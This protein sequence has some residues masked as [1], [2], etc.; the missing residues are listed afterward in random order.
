MRNISY[1]FCL[2][3]NAGRVAKQSGEL[4]KRAKILRNF[5][6]DYPAGDVTMRDKTGFKGVIVAVVTPFSDDDRPDLENLQRL[7]QTFYKQGVDGILL[8]G[9]TG[10][11]PSL[12]FEEQVQI[13]EVGLEVS[14]DLVVM[15]G[16]GCASLADT[17]RLTRRAFELGVDAAVTVPPFYF[18]KVNTAGLCEYYSRVLEEGVP[19]GRHLFLYDIPQ[20]TGIPITAELV[21]R[22]LERHEERLGGIKDSTGN[23]DHA[24]EYFQKFPGLRNFV[25]TDKLL[26]R[27]LQAGAAGCITAGANLFAPLAVEVYRAY[28]AGLDPAE[29]QERLSAARTALERYTP[30]PASLKSLLALRYNTPGWNVRPPLVP[31]TPAEREDLLQ[32]LQAIPGGI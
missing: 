1:L 19:D 12:S 28:Q 7:V 3:E 6:I 14:R 2:R 15:A 23:Y 26:L 8:L 20:T 9:T 13:L 11:G 21:E 17:I 5:Q 31:L 30:F 18:K 22:L 4:F 25:G 24:R 16:T 27:G 32:S 10:E 29:P